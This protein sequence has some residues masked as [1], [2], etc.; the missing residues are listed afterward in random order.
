MTS[1]TVKCVNC[2]VVI[3]EL[4][5]FIMN[6]VDVMDQESLVRICVS[7][8]DVEEVEKSKKLLFDSISTDIKNIKRKKKN[9]GKIQR[10]LEDILTVIKSTDP[11]KIPV[12]VAK[13]L[14]RLPPV[15]FDHVDVTSLLKDISLLKSQLDHIKNNYA[16]IDQLNELK[17][18]TENFKCDTLFC[19][20]SQTPSY[21]NKKAR[22]VNIADRESLSMNTPVAESMIERQR[23]N[24]CLSRSLP[25]FV[26]APAT[27]L[28]V[29]SMNHC[30]NEQAVNT[31]ETAPVCTDGVER[32]QK[33]QMNCLDQ[34]RTFAAAARNDKINQHY[35]NEGWT[36]VHNKRKINNNNK[37]TTLR[38]KARID[39]NSKFKPADT[40]IPLFITNVH[41]DVSEDDVAEYIF[42]RTKEK[43]VPIKIKMARERNYSAFKI[44]VSKVNLQIYLDDSMWPMGISFRRFV[45]MM[46]K[47]EN[48]QQRVTERQHIE[49]I[50]NG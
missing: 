26:N 31:S 29:G 40:K 13:E 20:P 30:D 12:F 11:E 2:N 38:G 24:D 4:L 39:E 33:R 27:A 25:G 16:T 43:V 21:I 7:S 35:D 1:H 32:K 17:L 19:T 8:F 3:D 48:H 22:R 44:Y 42:T 45:H 9:D 18:K 15:T 46:G 23:Q 49:D 34:N 41:K 28:D 50:I 36:L 6:K 47:N 10:D 37:F 5:T 14:H